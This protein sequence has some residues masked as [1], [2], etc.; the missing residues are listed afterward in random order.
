MRDLRTHLK[1]L[2]RKT[3]CFSKLEE[4]HNM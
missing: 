1:W 4:M 2:A 3:I